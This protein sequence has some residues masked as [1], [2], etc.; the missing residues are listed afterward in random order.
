[1][2]AAWPGTAGRCFSSTW[3]PQ[4]HSTIRVGIEPG[5]YL[6]AMQDVLVNRKDIREIILKTPIEGKF[7]FLVSN[8]SLRG[9]RKIRARYLSSNFRGIK[10]A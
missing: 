7:F 9:Q 1:L 6:V 8:R 2:H 3:T 5:S 10:S 4:A